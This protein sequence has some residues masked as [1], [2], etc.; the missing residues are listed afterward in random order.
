MDIRTQ[1][2]L[3]LILGAEVFDHG[4]EVCDDG[5]SIQDA[6]KMHDRETQMLKLLW[7][8]SIEGDPDFLEGEADFEE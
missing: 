5:L 2:I 7:E 1:Q 3:T 8:F 4:E 6:G